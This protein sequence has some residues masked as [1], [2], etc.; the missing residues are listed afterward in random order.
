MVLNLIGMTYESKKNA[1]L[2]RHLGAFFI[3]LNELGC[4]GVKLTRLVSIFTSKKS[5]E[6][7]DKN[8]ADKIRYKK[9][10]RVESALMPIRV[11]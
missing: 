5:L 6:I 8:S 11:K 10:K 2:S 3:R 7:F 4:E 9:D 1:H